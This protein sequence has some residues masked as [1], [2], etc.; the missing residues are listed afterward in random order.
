MAGI[1]TSLNAERGIAFWMERTLAERDKALK[2]FDVD[3]VHDLRTALRRCRSIAEAF[4]TLD[5]NLS[6]KRM[7]R[8]GKEI[9]SALG[10][11]R[12][13]QVLLEWIE[14]LKPACPSVAARLQSYCLQREIDL[15]NAAAEAV[16]AFDAQ[17]WLRW[18]REL[19]RRVQALD[20]PQQVFQLLALERL[21]SA[22]I[23]HATALRNRN[24]TALHQL[25][26]G[27][28]KFR[29]IVE[30]FL[31]EHHKSWG[32]DLKQIQDALGDV[33]DLD[34]LVDLSRQIHACATPEERQ[35][36]N[37]S[38]T[39][40]RQERIQTY[41]ER[42]VGR[43]S[44]WQVWRA[45]LPSGEALDQAVLKRF[46]VWANTLIP[47]TQ[48]TERITQF[49]LQLY[50]VLYA[51]GL[52]RLGDND[53]AKARRLL[54]VAATTHEVGY[55]TR[56]YHKAGRRLLHTLE[57][58]PGWTE[59]DISMIGL[60]V[61]F[62][63][64]ALPKEQNS[65]AQLSPDEKCLVDCLS[66]ILRFADSLDSEHD[67][68]IS[69]INPVCTSKLIEVVADG[70]KPRSRNATRIAAARCLLEEVC[71]VPLLVRNSAQS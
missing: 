51:A 31:P 26:I 6:W 42:M 15:K 50:D 62:H 10:E 12:D 18:S 47:E 17:R 29:Y 66:G 56:S 52:L 8:A 40:A 39:S 57:V 20:E 27:I 14:R 68:S 9:F 70:Y 61:R 21:E 67:A 24:K 34:V 46:E 30:N 19:E 53:R 63:R 36:F 44:L 48:H 65:Y 22:R 43:E 58:P 16:G 33:H 71:G 69:G 49:S 13:V 32:K 3:A 35:Q 54:H 55:G 60:I 38:V 7:R 5:G 25:R 2:D 64:G 11:L 23:L 37:T 45:S 4:Q 1:G 41:R 28:K 59:Q